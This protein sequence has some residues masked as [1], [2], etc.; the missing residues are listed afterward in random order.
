MIFK[1]NT[2]AEKDSSTSANQL[3]N[4]LS[5][6][7]QT[8]S[9]FEAIADSVEDKDFGMALRSIAVQTN[10]Y[11]NELDSQLKCMDVYNL[12]P[13]TQYKVDDLSIFA[14][15]ID[16]NRKNVLAVC[17]RSESFFTTAYQEILKLD[18]DYPFLKTMISS[19]F[20]GIRAAFMKMRLFEY[21]EV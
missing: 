3:C 5:Y 19:Q 9:E 21:G 12:S 4:M 17:D 20:D 8:T 1:K 13:Q 10:Q 6:L 15:T 11:A 2:S 18:F 7:K 14:N 16:K